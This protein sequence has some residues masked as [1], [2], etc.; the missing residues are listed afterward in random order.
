LLC[1]VFKLLIQD[2]LDGYAVKLFLYNIFQVL[3]DRA[4]Q[5]FGIERTG[6]VTGTTAE[7]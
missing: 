6:F 5:A 3:P 2:I 7:I 1:A 4:G